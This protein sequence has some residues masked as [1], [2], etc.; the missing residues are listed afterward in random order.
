[1]QP[2]AMISTWDGDELSFLR[3]HHQLR[4][5]R[6]IDL[7]ALSAAFEGALLAFERRGMEVLGVGL[8]RVVDAG[9]RAASIAAAL[10]AKGVRVRRFPNDRLALIAPLDL[11]LDE[12]AELGEWLDE[13]LR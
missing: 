4:D 10:E 8:Y 13:V 12:C 7:A 5:A 2:L 9:K 11:S 1:S 3:I 6:G